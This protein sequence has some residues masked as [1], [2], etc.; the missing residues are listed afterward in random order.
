[1]AV[2]RVL[3]TLLVEVRFE[4]WKEKR[5]NQLSVGELRGILDYRVNDCVGRLQSGINLRRFGGIICLRLQEY[6]R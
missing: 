3:H 1:M 6:S 2:G 5:T 4:L